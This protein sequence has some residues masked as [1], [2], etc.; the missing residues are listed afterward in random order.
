MVFFARMGHGPKLTLID[1]A[2]ARQQAEH[3]YGAMRDRLKE[4]LPPSTDIQHIGATVVP[5][6]LTKGDL[7]LV[8]RVPADAFIG[9]DLELSSRFARN[10]GSIHTESFSAFENSAS[11]P[12]VGIQLVV[13]DGPYDFF[14]HFA[15]ALRQSPELVAEY[16]S[17]KLAHDGFDMAVYRTAKD[18][19][20]ERVLA[21][22]RNRG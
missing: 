15:E 3:L 14:H 19:F 2:R 5:G 16:N 17:L 11:R 9:A 18:A 4:A 8:I 20:I 10:T 12:P 6:C 21:G 22:L 7:D 1:P 13:I